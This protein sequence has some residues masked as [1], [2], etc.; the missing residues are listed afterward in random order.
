AC[1]LELGAGGGYYLAA[2][3]D[4]VV[5]AP[6]ST[7]GGVGVVWNAYKLDE[8]LGLQ[9]IRVQTI[10]SGDNIDMGTP[11]K[12]LSAT[13]EAMLKGMTADYH[14]YFKARLRQ[15]RPK[16]AERCTIHGDADA[17]PFDGR[18]FA[19][20]QALACG[21]IDRLG[22]LEDAVAAAREMA[23]QPAAR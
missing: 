1:V 21:L 2:G 17:D 12:K 14:Q 10:K 11:L 23:R 9:S 4:Y 13:A 6:T 18:V 16:V 3:S 22:Y 20:G 7:V 8:A 5:A 15:V 19:A